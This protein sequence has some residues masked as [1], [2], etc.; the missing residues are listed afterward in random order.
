MLP[1]TFDVLVQLQRLT[2]LNMGSCE[3]RFKALP[4]SIGQMRALTTLDLYDCS[5]LAA[6]P[7]QIGQLQALTALNVAGSGLIGLPDS[8][9]HNFR[10]SPSWTSRTPTTSRFCPSPSAS[11]R[12]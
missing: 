5:S 6:L 9:T 8:L 1:G 3:Y 7:D 4:E 10:R 12:R 2:K 11:C